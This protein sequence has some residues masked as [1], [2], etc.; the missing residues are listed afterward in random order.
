MAEDTNSTKAVSAVASAI[1]KV[2][3]F[4]ATAE[5]AS[6]STMELSVAD[7]VEGSIVYTMTKEQFEAA[8][9][10]RGKIIMNYADNALYI[11]DGNKAVDIKTATGAAI[12]ASVYANDPAFTDKFAAK[13]EYASQEAFNQLQKRFEE[14]KVPD[15]SGFISKADADRDY[16]SQAELDNA[17]KIKET[18]NKDDGSKEEV[19][20]DKFATKIELAEVAA[21]I[22]AIDI[23]NFATI[24][25]LKGL[26]TETVVDGKID[27][28]LFDS[29]EEEVKV[30]VAEA[31][32][33]SKEDFWG[34]LTE[35]E[36]N[37]VI[38]ANGGNKPS[39]VDDPTNGPLVK[40]TVPEYTVPAHQDVT[41][42]TVKNAKYATKDDVTKAV[43]GVVVDKTTVEKIV[44][45][46]IA[47]GSLKIEGKA[48]ATGAAGA[49][50]ADG[51]SAFEIANALQPDGAKF[52]NEAAW[53]ASLKGKDGSDATVDTSKFA[54][55]EDL[56]AKQDK[57]ADGTYAAAAS[58]YTKKEVDD[59]I[60]H[61]MEGYVNASAVN[62]QIEKIVSED[63]ENHIVSP[64]ELTA[65]L[66]DYAKSADLTTANTAIAAKAD[67]TYVDS[68]F[69]AKTDIAN[70][71]AKT[72]IANLAA[73]TDLPDVSGFILKADVEKNYVLRSNYD[74]LVARVT[75]LENAGKS[76]TP[77]T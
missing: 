29:K 8:S 26:A 5:T 52:A 76:T 65:A 21:K 30:D 27:T 56:A 15:V 45:D 4:K 70:L 59:A 64:T 75:A 42:K 60:L 63:V 34:A 37:R 18:I 43:A 47:D 25:S 7:P 17:L 71:A 77:T 20:K 6:G 10:S 48:G 19:V 23:K 39:G 57:S 13:G 58:T 69:A 12:A 50:G 53:L 72:D 33:P 61:G 38:K 74:A 31:H 11:C 55:K 40:V 66:G 73:K 24:D 1:K 14:M 16:L 54:S 22:P 44:N 9:K 36:K 3:G 32:Y 49:N 46:G 2:I 41:K 35:D 67:K 28:A 68:T 62:A 51:K